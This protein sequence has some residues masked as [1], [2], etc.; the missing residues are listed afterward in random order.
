[1]EI[2]VSTASLFMRAGTKDALDILNA[3]DARVVEIFLESFSEYNAEYISSLKN[4]LGS[5]KVNS[6]HTVTT[7]FEPQL[8]SLVDIQKK[9]A[10]AFMREIC[11]GAKLIGA[12]NYTL[13]GRARVK[14]YAKLD[15]FDS[16]V[17]YFNE[18]CDL[19]SEYDME[20]CLE[21][22]EWCFYSYPEWFSK[23]KER[24]PKLKTCLDV[25]Q[26]RIS[27]YK[28]EDYIREMAGRINTVH[29]S[30][31]DANGKMCLPGKGVTDFK[32][33]FERLS[34]TGFCGNM[35]IEVYTG[36]YG[37]IDEIADSLDYLRD[38][39]TGVFKNEKV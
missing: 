29:L 37:A 33:L 26:A 15:D 27:G 14:K 35:L 3:I 22:V 28:A 23:I 30:D 10:Y 2:G 8:F 21:N 18:L 31:V 11:R 6:L 9:D 34:D 38:I 17:P 12:K 4:R 19:L 36:D 25:K 32:A 5:L 20:L 16:Y 24:C 7:Q 39:F 13:H 1:M